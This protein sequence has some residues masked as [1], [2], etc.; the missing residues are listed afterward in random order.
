MKNLQHLFFT[1]FERR[2]CCIATSLFEQITITRVY[3]FP[4]NIRP[5]CQAIFQFINRTSL[6]TSWNLKVLVIGQ[7]QKQ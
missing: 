2:I 5:Y 7:V 1:Q 3:R 4:V 6:I